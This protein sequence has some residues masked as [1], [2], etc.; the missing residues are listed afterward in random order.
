MRALVAA[1][2]PGNV[3]Q[4]DQTVAM[5]M[6]EAEG[7]PRITCKHLRYDL[8]Y[9][10]DFSAANEDEERAEI[11]VALAQASNHRGDAARL[12]S[13]SRSHF[14][15]RLDKLNMGGSENRYADSGEPSDREA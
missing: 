3:R 9:L 4:L 1:P 12:L 5:L 2:W 6:I 8:Q 13:M 7:A 14:Y 10:A 15:R 11:E